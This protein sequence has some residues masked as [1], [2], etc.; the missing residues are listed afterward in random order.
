MSGCVRS[1]P[2]AGMGM[3][4]RVYRARDPRAAVLEGAIERLET[5]GVATERLSLARAIEKA[6][7][8]A[9]HEHK[10][11]RKLEANVEFY[12]AVLLDVVGLP[13]T[14]FT[15][16]FAVSRVAGWLAHF[17]EQRESGRLIRPRAHYIGPMPR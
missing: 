11:D 16:T 2:R 15:P 4:H 7:R 8:D 17:M 12:T 1:W 10:P 14:L 3:G 13:R 9:L 5:A 6:A